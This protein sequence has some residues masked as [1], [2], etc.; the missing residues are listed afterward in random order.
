[1]VSLPLILIVSQF[2]ACR[3]QYANVAGTPEQDYD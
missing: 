1:M 2:D 3:K